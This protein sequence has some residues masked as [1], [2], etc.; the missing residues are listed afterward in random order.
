[1]LIGDC[2]PTTTYVDALS[3]SSF[4]TSDDE[5]YGYQATRKR[6]HG[7]ASDV[8]SS[9]DDEEI[10]TILRDEDEPEMTSRARDMTSEKRHC[11]PPPRASPVV[12]DCSFLQRPSLNLYKMQ[13]GSSCMSIIYVSLAEH[14]GKG[15]FTPIFEM[16]Q[17]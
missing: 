1:M 3:L 7:N 13:V 10:R 14:T 8:T 9:D 2:P 17:Q 6:R 4:S 12:A 15:A 11:A 5:S 16:G